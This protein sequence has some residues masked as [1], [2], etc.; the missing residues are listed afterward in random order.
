MKVVSIVE[1]R[2]NEVLPWTLTW[3]EQVER[4]AT[5]WDALQEVKRRDAEAVAAGAKVAMTKV[6]WTPT[7]V[8]GHAV[9]RVLAGGK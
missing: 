6:E 7:T 4:F 1:D 5:A 3:N 2:S 9:V 8:A